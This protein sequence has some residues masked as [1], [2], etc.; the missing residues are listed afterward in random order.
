MGDLE[1]LIS[2]LQ[3]AQGDLLDDALFELILFTLINPIMTT[4]YLGEY[5]IS[6]ILITLIELTARIRRWQTVI[7]PLPIG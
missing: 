4:K 2:L 5:A 1:N 3:M 7:D 6:S